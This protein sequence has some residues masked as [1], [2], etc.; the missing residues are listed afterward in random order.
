FILKSQHFR[1]TALPGTAPD[2]IYPFFVSMQASSSVILTFP[3]SHTTS[4]N[5]PSPDGTFEFNQTFAT[6]AAFDTAFPNGS[7]RFSGSGIPPVLL[8]LSPES[9]PVVPQLT[10]V[11]Q[12]A[13]NAGGILVVNPAQPLTL[14]I[15]N[16]T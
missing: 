2:T 16:F 6:K 9:Y 11:S 3:D 7:Y 5:T 4:L 8:S 13:F 15:N 14:N 12:G 10:S 1:Q